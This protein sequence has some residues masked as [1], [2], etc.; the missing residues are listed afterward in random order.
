M[1]RMVQCGRCGGEGRSEAW[2]NTGWE[3]FDC[4]GAGEVEAT[5]RAVAKFERR[6]FDEAYAL[7]DQ[8]INELQDCGHCLHTATRIAAELH[9]LR[10]EGMSRESVIA[11]LRKIQKLDA[12][13]THGPS[14][15]YAGRDIARAV[16][17][18]G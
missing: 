10:G 15:R 13:G 4:G 17:D 5:P 8:A 2:R 16:V 18:A 9:R 12:S 3:C 11:W 7:V 1:V 6:A 14:M